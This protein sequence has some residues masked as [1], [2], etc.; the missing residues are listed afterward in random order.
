M[1]LVYTWAMPVSSLKQRADDSGRLFG[2]WRCWLMVA[3]AMFGIFGASWAVLGNFDPFGIYTSLLARS[4]W[5]T[6]Q[7]TSE[8]LDTFAFMAVPLGA[9]TAGYFV[10]VFML[11]RFA[12][13]QR[14]PWA[15]WTVV[16]ALL[17]WFVI[18]SVFSGLHGAYFNIWLVNLPCL[19]IMGVP[20]LMLRNAFA[21]RS[22]ST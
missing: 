7:P 21:G 11:V 6:G 12:F 16:A 1:G 4:Q 18:D 3:S 17:T 10:M 19:L 2:F 14:Q 5:G 15:Y 22:R 8:A 20:L 13:A 9:T